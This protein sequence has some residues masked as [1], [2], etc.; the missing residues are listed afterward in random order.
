[1]SDL[2][3]KIDFGNEAADDIDSE[4]LDKFFIVQPL[5]NKFLD[6]KNRILVATGKKGIGKSALLKWT[7]YN[8]SKSD[9]KAIVIN[10]RG[11]DLVRQRFHLNTPLQTPND[12]IRDWMVRICSLVNRTLAS[13]FKIALTDDK[14]TLIE[15]AEI[16]GYK[17]RNLVGCLIDRFHKKGILSTEKKTIKDELEILKRTTEKKL[18]IF[19]DDLDATFQTTREALLELATFFSACR[20]LTQDLNDIHFRITMR[21]DVW[22]VIRRFDESLDKMDQYVNDILWYQSDFRKLLSKRIESQINQLNY[23]INKPKKFFSTEEKD[24][25]FINH[26]F[27]PKMEWGDKNIYTYKVLYTLSYERPRWFIQLC[28]L[29]QERATRL[30]SNKI[31]RT[32]INDIWGEY[33]KK[34][35]DDLISEHKHQCDQI[36]ELLNSFRGCN[37]LLTRGELFKWINN[38]ILT[39]LTPVIEGEQVPNNRDVARFLFK[40]GFIVARSDNEDGEHYEHYSFDQMTDFLSSRTDDDFSVKWEIHPCYREAL[41]IKKINRSHRARFERLRKDK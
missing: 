3:K 29:S 7:K 32:H 16:E 31:N 39:H 8:V 6:P 25:Y 9:R 23:P 4:E 15:C 27:V 38:R 30:Q 28:K 14:I 21:T 24:E 33:G 35:I 40:I 10:A 36:E 2:L 34:R 1:M 17:S 22:S 41:D 11:A 26:I 13:Y 20:Y 19:I 37:R 18:W 5:F 12:Y